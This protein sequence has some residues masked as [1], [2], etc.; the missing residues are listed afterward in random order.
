[1]FTASRAGSGLVITRVVELQE[2]IVYIYMALWFLEGMQMPSLVLQPSQCHSHVTLVALRSNFSTSWGPALS[3]VPKFGAALAFHRCIQDKLLSAVNWEDGV[4]CCTMHCD[5][6]GKWR[7]WYVDHSAED[8]CLKKQISSTYGLSRNSFWGDSGFRRYTRCC[9]S[10]LIRAFIL[11]LVG[12]K[13]SI[14]KMFTTVFATVS[15]SI[16]GIPTIAEFNV[17]AF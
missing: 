3:F 16:I 12:E 2:M 4:N 1:M 15:E 11:S 5:Y 8:S 13:K 9:Q 7:Q 17:F 6:R 10:K 14:S